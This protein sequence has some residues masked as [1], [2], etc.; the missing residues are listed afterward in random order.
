MVESQLYSKP[1]EIAA[2]FNIPLVFMGE[3]PALSM[4]KVRSVRFF[5]L[6]VMRKQK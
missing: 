2:A 4:V 5:I 3:N 6:Q 1:L